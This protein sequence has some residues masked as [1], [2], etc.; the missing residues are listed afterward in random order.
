MRLASALV[1]VFLLAEPGAIAAVPFVADYTDPQGDIE[2][3][4]S[5]VV[6]VTSSVA[7]GVVTQRV[8]MAAPPDPARD[9]LILRSWFHNS[10]NGSF[11][12]VDLEFHASGG[13]R[14]IVRRDTFDN[15]T[16]VANASTYAVEGYAHVFTFPASLVADATCFD[17]IVWAQHRLVEDDR[18]I[19]D[20]GGVGARACRTRGDPAVSEPGPPLVPVVTGAF[21]PPDAP[22]VEAPGT[23]APPPG[24]ATLF[25]IGII[26]G[27]AFLVGRRSLQG[28]KK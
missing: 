15:V 9:T 12:V 8:E 13:W 22:R 26:L 19:V 17:P 23:R 14:A 5:D 24:P 27:I 6:R 7:G 10:T 25:A 1:L 28:A 4:S 3:A 2:A 21:V 18:A 16:N 11:D 20:V